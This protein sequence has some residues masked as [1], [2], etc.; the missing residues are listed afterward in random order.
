MFTFTLPMD[1]P[2]N[3][4]LRVVGNQLQAK[5]SFNFEVKSSYSVSVRVAG[6]SRRDIRS[7]IHD[8]SYRRHEGPTAVT[9]TNVVNTLQEDT[10]A[11][12]SDSSG[13]YIGVTDDFARHECAVAVRTRC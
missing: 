9:L 7:G 13:G 2:T 11:D 4:L 12:S 10:P 3:K 1:R 8:Q 6:I 5:S